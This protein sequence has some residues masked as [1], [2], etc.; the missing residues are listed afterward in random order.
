MQGTRIY[1]SLGKR[2][3]QEREKRR[4][5]RITGD[6]SRGRYEHN[7]DGTHRLHRDGWC[8]DGDDSELYEQLTQRWRDWFCSASRSVT[9]ASP[10]T[11]THPFACLTNGRWDLVLASAPSSSNHFSNAVIG[12]PIWSIDNASLAFFSNLLLNRWKLWTVLIRAPLRQSSS[13]SFFFHV[14]INSG[15]LFCVIIPSMFAHFLRKNH[16]GKNGPSFVQINET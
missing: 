7:E 8:D 11:P 10:R 6:S 13:Y 16:Q 14:S 5:N 15:I 3:R 9:T 1:I 12:L 4:C 2:E